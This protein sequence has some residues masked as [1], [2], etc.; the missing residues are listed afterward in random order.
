MSAKGIDRA[1]IDRIAARIN[2]MYRNRPDPRPSV[3][4]GTVQAVGDCTYDVLMPDGA[5]LLG[6]KRTVGA[7]GAAVGSECLIEW[8]AG[9]AYVTGVVAT[10]D[11]SP[12][13]SHYAKLLWSGDLRYGEST[14]VDGLP[15]YS[16]FVFCFG[17]NRD[18]VVYTFRAGSYISG[19]GG[20]ADRNGAF[21][22]QSARASAS[23]TTLTLI[24][25]GGLSIWGVSWE[26]T[27][28]DRDRNLTAIY[29]LL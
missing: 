17:A 20:Y 11:S 12:D 25:D 6:V 2:G 24:D 1:E 4:R 28:F 19:I 3:T 9:S 8:I 21:R 26:Y 7:A 5:V 14:V 27:S 13:S 22:I 18:S 16:A 10:A 29:G 15:D 23:G